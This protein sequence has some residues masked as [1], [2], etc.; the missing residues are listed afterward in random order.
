MHSDQIEPFARY[1]NKLSSEIYNLEKLRM[2]SGTDVAAVTDSPDK[3]YL[4]GV[5]DKDDAV[6]MLSNSGYPDFVERSVNNALEAQ[7]LLKGKNRSIVSEPITYGRYLGLSFAVWPEQKPISENKIIRAIQKR[8][9]A[10]SVFE[11]LR[12]AA[13]DTLVGDLDETTVE[14]FIRKPLASIVQNPKHNRKSV[15]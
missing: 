6:V 7:K 14:E 4:P 5:L 13:R 11:W 15:V 12:L 8:L 9:I 10:E 2:I 3:F 1:I